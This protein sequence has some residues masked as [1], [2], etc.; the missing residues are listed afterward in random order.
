[1]DVPRSKFPKPGRLRKLRLTQDFLSFNGL[2]NLEPVKFR[3]LSSLILIPPLV[4]RDYL[5]L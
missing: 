4:G 3:H 1:M 5:L 2:R